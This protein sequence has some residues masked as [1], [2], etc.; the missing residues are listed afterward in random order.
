MNSY[1]VVH[2]AYCGMSIP[3]AEGLT[4]S[5]A[6]ARVKRRVDWFRKTM[7]GP[8]RW[9]GPGDVELEE[10]EDVAMVPDAY[11]HTRIHKEA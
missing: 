1:K 3:L 5:E 9:W 2:H 11:G 8:V 7:G 4:W 10:P 6:R